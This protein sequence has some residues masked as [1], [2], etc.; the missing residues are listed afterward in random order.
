MNPPLI[1]FICPCYNHEKY[2]ATFLD[3]LLQ[4]T[5]SNWRLILINDCS[6]DG[7]ANELAK[8]NDARIRVV[9]NSCNR[10]MTYGL[11]VGVNMAET[12]IIAFVASDDIILPDY[13]DAILGEFEKSDIVATYTTMQRMNEHGDIY[14][15]VKLLPSEK[16]EEEL[17]AS[18][19]LGENILNSPGM[20]FRKS[21][22][23]CYFPM[24]EGMIQYT[25]WQL[26]LLVTFSGRVRIMPMPLVRYRVSDVSLCGGRADVAVREDVEMSLLMDTVVDLIGGDEEQFQRFF[27]DNQVVRDYCVTAPTIP[28]WLGR[29]ALT[30]SNPLKRR[31]GY[32]K[33]MEYMADHE[34]FEV[35]HSLYK[36][37]FKEYVKLA[38]TTGLTPNIAWRNKIRKYRLLATF[39]WVIALVLLIALVITWSC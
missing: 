18:L 24:N 13:V 28:F 6:S 30:S 38:P 9:T 17:F 36:F 3:S 29:M 34:K 27:G 21:V 33:V 14:K 12:D 8:Y 35:I 32:Y 39:L 11:N 1:T 19:F 23:S 5:D 37:D 2:V 4:Q 15:R 7:T 20:A 25:D 31:W 22:L 26:H 16:S 10:G